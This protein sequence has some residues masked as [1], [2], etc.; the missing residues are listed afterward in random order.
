MLSNM[1]A[2]L[3]SDGQAVMNSE[4]REIQLRCVEFVASRGCVEHWPDLRAL[5]GNDG[6][7]YDLFWAEGD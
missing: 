4:A 3:S 1:Y 6:S 2:L 7:K 5:N